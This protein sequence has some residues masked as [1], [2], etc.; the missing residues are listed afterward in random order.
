MLANGP[1][2]GE[3]GGM[4]FE[5]A[6]LLG[7]LEGAERQARRQLLEQLYADGVELE[8]L[9]AAIAEHRLPLV[10]VDRVLGGRLSAREIERRTGVPQALVLRIRRLSGL[11]AA[12]PDDAVFGDEDIAMAQS[13]KLFLDA[14][15]SEDTLALTTRVLGEGMSRLAATITATFAEAFL[16]PGDNEA[17]VALRFAELTEQLTPALAPVLIAAFKAH[18]RESVG[19]GMLRRAEITSGRLAGEQEVA[20]CFADVVGFTRLGG[21]LDGGEL[22][23]VAGR[24][25]E[26]ANQVAESPV[27]LVKTIGDA[28]MLVSQDTAA[29]VAA[30]LALVTAMEEAELPALRAGLACGTAQIQAGDYYGH[31]VNIASRVTGLARP[32]SVLCTTEVRDAAADAFTWSSAGR[33]RLKGVQGAVALHRAHP[34]P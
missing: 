23:V 30:A 17:D 32:G 21:Q 3:D 26:L 12:S 18:L 11:P 29:L 28:A 31:P 13:T 25:G 34:L 6:G 9:R 5:A 27:R 14:G 4:D 1:N 33:H 20:V 22:G 10:P 7:E 8:E 19:R 24:L 15:I 2:M 16:R